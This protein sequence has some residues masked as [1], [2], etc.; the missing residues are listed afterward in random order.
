MSSILFC[1]RMKEIKK[2][3][4]IGL[5]AIGSFFASRLKTAADITVVAG[6]EK[7]DGKIAGAEK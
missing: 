7:N 1:Y 6:G 4:I 5:G 3:S 2:V